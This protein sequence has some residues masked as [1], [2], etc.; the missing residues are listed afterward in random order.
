[1]ADVHQDVHE[2]TSNVHEITSNVHEITSNGKADGTSDVEETI[3]PYEED[4]VTVSARRNVASPINAI[5]LI[6]SNFDIFQTPIKPAILSR[7]D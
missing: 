5:K 6:S 3:T 4:Q 7:Y 1:M 2:I